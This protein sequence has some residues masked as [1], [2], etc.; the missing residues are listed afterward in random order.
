M[1][2]LVPSMRPRERRS[3]NTDTEYYGDRVCISIPEDPGGVPEAVG[4][5]AQPASSGGAESDDAP[6]AVAP[7]AQA[8]G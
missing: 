2:R 4:A 5:D 3:C 7:E 8:G 1:R 6:A